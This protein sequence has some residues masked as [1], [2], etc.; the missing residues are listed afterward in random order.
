MPILLTTLA[1]VFAGVYF[2]RYCYRSASWPKSFVKTMSVLLL[3][4]AAWSA[5][6]PGALIVA[7]LL[8]A[9]G[10]YLL[11]RDSEPL[12]MAGVGAFAAGHIA[13]VWLFLSHPASDSSRILAGNRLPIILGL[14]ALGVI[15]ARTLWHRAG[16]MRWPVMGYI[17]VI[18]SMG[19]AV[20]AVSTLGP[21]GL[22]ILG[23][24]LFGPRLLRGGG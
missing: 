24:A 4:L 23:A 13:Y 20:L 22:A 18:L 10:D 9:L 11:S 14:A 8:C 12:F 1:G 7:L 6:G 5:A 17:P 19:V 3:A 16:E 15:M 21:L 2:F